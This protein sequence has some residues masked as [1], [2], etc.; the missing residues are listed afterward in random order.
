VLIFSACKPTHFEIK[1]N[2]SNADGET[3]ILEKLELDRNIVMDTLVLGKSG[4]FSFDGDQLEVPSFFRLSLSPNNFITLLIDSTEQLKVTADGSHLED[5]YRLEGSLE[6]KKIQILNQR[7]KTLRGSVDSLLTLYQS[8]QSKKELDRKKEIGQEL[9]A[10]LEE[11]KQFIGTFVMDNPRS[12]ASYYALFQRLSDNTLVLNVMDKKEQVYFAAIATS[13][14]LLYPESPRVK[15]L[16][17]YV[18]SAKAEQQ[19]SKVT[20]LLESSVAES[21]PEIREKTVDGE[22]VALSSLK[23][24]VVLLSFWASWDKGSVADNQELKKIY[25][26]FHKKGFEVYQVSLDRSK[27]LWENAIV[28]NELPWINVSDLQ[29][30]DSYPA[31]IYNIKQLPANYLISREGEIIGKNLFGNLLREKLDELY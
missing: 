25:G 20:A 13:L 30:T 27:V 12:F 22:E 31:R 2:I 26:D 1:G 4:R 29:Y 3:L 24:K 19:R 16:Y 14:N 5:S 7:L 18:L 8:L 15:Q 28:S 11:H 10:S 23:G 17:N 6:S 21:I 9:L